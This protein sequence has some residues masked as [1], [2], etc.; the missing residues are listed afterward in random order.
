MTSESGN[1]RSSQQTGE[2]AKRSKI[3][4]VGNAIHAAENPSSRIYWNLHHPKLD[5]VNNEVT[6]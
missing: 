1:F 6:L 3:A 2:A 4:R 5:L